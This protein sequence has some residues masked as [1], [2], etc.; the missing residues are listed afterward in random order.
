MR[1]LW[2]CGMLRVEHVRTKHN[3][4]DICTKNLSETIHKAHRERIRNGSLKFME[5]IN[6]LLHTI[7]R[8]GVVDDDLSSVR[9]GGEVSR[10][11]ETTVNRR[12]V[13]AMTQSTNSKTIGLQFEKKER[14][15]LSKTGIDEPIRQRP[16]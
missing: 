4:T 12:T 8:E 3:E 11:A 6:A 14:I 15:E 16:P 10:S 9:I 7:R 2:E 5:N 13:E 1:D